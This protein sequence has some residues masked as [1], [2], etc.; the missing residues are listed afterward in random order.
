M[1]F[2]SHFS[3]DEYIAFKEEYI[4]DG[5]EFHNVKIKDFIEHCLANFVML[6]TVTVLPDYVSIDFVTVVN[7]GDYPQLKS[8]R[9]YIAGKYYEEAVSKI[10]EVQMVIKAKLEAMRKGWD[11]L[12]NERYAGLHALINTIKKEKK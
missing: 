6:D 11:E 10:N 4:G 5:L 1:G 3:D 2:H 9:I 8:R 12:G 7:D